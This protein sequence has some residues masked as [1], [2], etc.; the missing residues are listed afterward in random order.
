MGAL[1]LGAGQA[2]TEC[3]APALGEVE[4]LIPKTP[5]ENVYSVRSASLRAG[6]RQQGSMIFQSLSGTSELVP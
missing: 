4:V 2:K 3:A 5:A 6:L 1:R